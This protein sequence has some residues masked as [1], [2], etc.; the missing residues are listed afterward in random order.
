MKRLFTNA[1]NL[2]KSLSKEKVQEGDIVIDATMGNGNDTAFL[3]DLVGSSGRVYAFD[4]Q[5]EAIKNT[6]KRLLKM[7]FE[8][9]AKL[10]HD[11]HENIDSHV[12]EGVSFIIYNL[13]YL[14]KGNHEITTKSI[15]TIQSLEKSLEVLND[16]GLIVIVVYPGHENGKKEKEALANFAEKLNQSK[17]SVLNMKFTNQI[18]NPPE[19]ICIEKITS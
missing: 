7:G 5:E 18:N 4:I 11:G 15:T 3:C 6:Y 19:L 9:R 17:F 1:V 10:I 13:G 8:E 14:P 12:R 16:N 2:S